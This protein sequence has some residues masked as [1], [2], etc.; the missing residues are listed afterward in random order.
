MVQLKWGLRNTLNTVRLSREAVKH[1]CICP[2]I[3]GALRALRMTTEV[4][5]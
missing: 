4:L 5:R 2:K 1:L 3:L